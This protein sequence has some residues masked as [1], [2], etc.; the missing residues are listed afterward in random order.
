[1]LIQHS[2]PTLAFKPFTFFRPLRIFSFCTLTT[3]LCSW[4]FLFT[5]CFLFSPLIASEFFNEMLG[6]SEARA[7]NFYT[8]FRLI[9]LTLSVSSNLTLTH[10]PLSRFLDSLLCDVMAPA[11]GLVF[12]LLMSHTLAAASSFSL[13]TVCPS[14]SF[15]SPLSLFA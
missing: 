5:F 10:F 3:A 8:L 14:L 12:F 1:M 2:H 11:P 6:V 15:L 9:R 4:L 13:G 7:L